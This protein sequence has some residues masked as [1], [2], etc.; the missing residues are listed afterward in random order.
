[1]NRVFDGNSLNLSTQQTPQKVNTM[2]FMLLRKSKRQAVREIARRHYEDCISVG[3][4]IDEAKL[5]AEK[6]IRTEGIVSTILI[7][8]AIRLAFMLIEHWF[9]SGVTQ[10]TGDYDPS[11]PGF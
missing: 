4:D 2:K 7:S 11:E 5:N 3:L 8:I 6:E 1:M 9:F 10:V